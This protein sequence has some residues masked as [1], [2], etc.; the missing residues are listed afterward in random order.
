M[1]TERAYCERQTAVRWYGVKIEPHAPYARYLWISFTSR[2]ERRVWRRGAYPGEPKYFLI[3]TSDGTPLYDS[4]VDVPCDMVEW[5]KMR[6]E[7]PLQD[8]RQFIHVV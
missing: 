7:H 1:I 8:I 5:A 2:R 6:E 4:R 3:A